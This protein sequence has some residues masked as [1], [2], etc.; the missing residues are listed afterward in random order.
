[1]D[2][3]AT[4]QITL[5]PVREGDLPYFEQ[6]ATPHSDPWNFFGFRRPGRMRRE[7]HE[8]G[9]LEADHAQLVID[10]DG[11]LIGD[12]GWHAVWYGPPPAAGQA[13]NI[14]IT[15]LPEHRGK[16]YGSTA[17]RLLA[18]Y[19]FDTYSINRVEAGTD[20]ENVAEQRALEKAGFTREGVLRG[21][22]WRA[23]AWH[24]MV[25]YSRLRDDA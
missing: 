9:L 25:S 18:D 13:L 4:P 20:V 12:I 10:L 2:N 6:G 21:S 22:Q 1:V 14:G 8:N 24:D 16:G 19:L 23:G 5:R 11:Q 17:Q 7:F 3:Q 15:L